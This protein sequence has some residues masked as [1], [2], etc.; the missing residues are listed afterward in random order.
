MIQSGRNARDLQHVYQ[1]VVHVKPPELV[2]TENQ[3]YDN[4]AVGLS[5]CCNK[6]MKENQVKSI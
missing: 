2:Q 5:H 3:I 4:T 6:E 1:T